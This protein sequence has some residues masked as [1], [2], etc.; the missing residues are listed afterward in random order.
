MSGVVCLALQH[1]TL[2][3]PS[4]S[5]HPFPPSPAPV[6]PYCRGKPHAHIVLRLAGREEDIPKASEDI[7]ALISA[8]IPVV[9]P[10]CH[11][12]ACTSGEGHCI[13]VRKREAVVKHMMHKCAVGVCMGREEPRVCRRG[14]PKAICEMAGQDDG[15]YPIYRRGVADAMVVPHNVQMLLKYDCHIN[16]EICSSAWVYRYMVRFLFCPSPLPSIITLTLY[17]PPPHPHP[18]THICTRGL[19]RCA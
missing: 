3:H 1:C 13:Q 7:D 5:S 18:S 12:P 11:C 14:Y 17:A 16:V 4:F 19:T 2:S 9:E 8:C 6:P 10:D 15:G